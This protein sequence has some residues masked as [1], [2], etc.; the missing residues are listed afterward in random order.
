M[1]PRDHWGQRKGR[2]HGTQRGNGVRTVRPGGGGHRRP[3][4]PRGGRRVGRGGGPTRHTVCGGQGADVMT[5]LD[6]SVQPLVMVA[7]LPGPGVHL[8][9]AGR[10]R[11]GL[12]EQVDSVS[13]LVE[14]A[15]DGDQ[16]AWDA[17]VERYL[18]LVCGTIARTGLYG[19]EAEDVNQTVWL[20]L[21][22]HLDE[23]REPLALPGWIATTARR[24]C[25]R[26]LQKQSRLVPVDPQAGS[27]QL[28]S[29]SSQPA[30]DEALLADE[31]R[32]ALRDG[33]AELPEDRR[34]L[35]LLLLEDPPLPYREISARLG[36]PVGSIGPTRVRA[37]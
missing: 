14:R 3:D 32:Q 36:I 35:L 12:M 34:A 33:L 10:R 20:R 9:L 15:R 27:T 37:L 13:S 30:L 6:P 25:I 18:P 23:I 24:E 22:E 16:G 8:S 31:R 29:G 19:A 2:S 21:V 11:G 17:L 7:G 1:T 28:E 5:M 26:A 4:A